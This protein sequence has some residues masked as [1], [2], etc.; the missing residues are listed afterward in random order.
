MDSD[1]LVIESEV[2]KG[3]FFEHVFNFEDDSKSE[4]L[5]I[6]QYTILAIIP[7]IILNKSISKIIPRVDHTKSSLEIA[8]EIL[9][10]TG[11][12][13][14]GMLL[15]HRFVT[16]FPTYSK[17]TYASLHIT[18]IIM[19]LLV[20]FVSFQTRIG[21]KTNILIDRFFDILD[22]KTTIAPA[23]PAKIITHPMENPNPVP[24]HQ[25]SR[26]DVNHSGTTSIHQLQGD[27]VNKAVPDFN[28][29]YNGPTNP[30]VNAQTPSSKQETF[31]EIQPA[32]HFGGGLNTF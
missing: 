12:L 8:G 15:I 26:A 3:S 29:M 10:Q 11:F 28:T 30:L 13:F 22:G 27:E 17:K 25:A 32:N 19:G 31:N 18:N 7:V 24:Q 16:Y 1:K 6:I 4:M 23:S 5:N 14:L 20:V 2:K 9:G 21:E